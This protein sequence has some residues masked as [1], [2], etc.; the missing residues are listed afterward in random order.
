MQPGWKVDTVA[1]LLSL[2]DDI[3]LEADTADSVSPVN[4]L[5]PR[6]SIP[7]QRLPVVISHDE[8]GQSD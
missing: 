7:S 4:I 3:R 6:C 8:Y 2:A 5:Q 1:A